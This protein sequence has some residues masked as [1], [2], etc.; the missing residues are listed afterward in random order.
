MGY[1]Q[2]EADDRKTKDEAG[3]ETE[4]IVLAGTLELEAGIRE[5][6]VFVK[7]VGVGVAFFH[8]GRILF[9]NRI[10]RGLQFYV[11]AIKRLLVVRFGQKA[12]NDHDEEWSDDLERKVQGGEGGVADLGQIVPENLVV[13]QHVEAELPFSTLFAIGFLHPSDQ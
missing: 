5:E 11:E 6:L 12:G 10:D 4:Y 3:K 7:P 8:F 13:E 1:Q 2:N 9:R